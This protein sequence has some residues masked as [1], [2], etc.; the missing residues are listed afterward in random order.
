MINNSLDYISVDYSIA[1]VQKEP[2]KQ[3]HVSK[4]ETIQQYTELKSATIFTDRK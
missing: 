1:S 2:T 3:Q 4:Q